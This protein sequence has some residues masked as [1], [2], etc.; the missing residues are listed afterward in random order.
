MD[1]TPGLRCFA[2]DRLTRF[3]GVVS[4]I[5]VIWGFHYFL[6]ELHGVVDQAGAPVENLGCKRSEIVEIFRRLKPR[7]D[8]FIPICCVDLVEMSAEWVADI[9]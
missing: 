4:I 9:R 2:P 7:I 8:Q 5:S 6:Q 3:T 1:H